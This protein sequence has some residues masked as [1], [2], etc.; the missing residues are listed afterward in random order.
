MSPRKAGQREVLLNGTQ[1]K[2]RE[3]AQ[4]MGVSTQ[5]F[6]VIKK[7]LASGTE[8]GSK[9]VGRCEREQKTTWRTD[10]QIVKMTHKN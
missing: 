8:L 2:Q 6:S 5:F 10:R 4:K 9:T 7:K 3:I 1:L